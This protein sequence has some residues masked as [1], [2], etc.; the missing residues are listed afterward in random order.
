MPPL[1]LDYQS[2][3]LNVKHR[4]EHSHCCFPIKVPM[5]RV[6]G[7][8]VHPAPISCESESYS[9]AIAL[10]TSAAVYSSGSS[11]VPAIWASKKSSRRFL[12]FAMIS[13]ASMHGITS[14]KCFARVLLTSANCAGYHRV[15]SLL[16]RRSSRT[17]ESKS[18]VVAQSFTQSSKKFCA[19]N[20]ARE[21]RAIPAIAHAALR[22]W[23][24]VADH[25]EHKFT[26]H[27]PRLL[28]AQESKSRAVV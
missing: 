20:A 7:I 22:L 23:G 11:A 14:G 16:Q 24:H 13:V 19:S 8:P 26:C 27:G 5:K 25:H 10:F 15:T 28:A 2:A 17:Q 1:P 4:V 18:K 3:R 9:S 12:M 6:Y 21:Y